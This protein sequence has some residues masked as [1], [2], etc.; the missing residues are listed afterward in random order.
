M[1][2]SMSVM[3]GFHVGLRKEAY[4]WL[5][6]RMG[7]LSHPSEE[8]V[9]EQREA[10]RDFGDDEA[11]ALWSQ[12]LWKLYCKERYDRRKMRAPTTLVLVSK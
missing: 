12:L 10:A 8:Y 3:H 9:R 1:M 2:V 7:G 6:N 4:D 11:V 5:T